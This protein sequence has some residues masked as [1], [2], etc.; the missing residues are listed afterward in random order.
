M[1]VQLRRV[2]WLSLTKHIAQEGWTFAP[3]SLKVVWGPPLFIS[4]LGFTDIE[5]QVYKVLPKSECRFYFD[6]MTLIGSLDILQQKILQH[7][8]L[9]VLRAILAADV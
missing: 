4:F 8:G 1:V 9:T 7:D 5:L 6:G 3:L 2:A